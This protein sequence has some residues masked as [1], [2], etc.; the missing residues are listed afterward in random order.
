[1]NIKLYVRRVF[2]TEECDELCPDYLTFLKV[3][4]CFTHRGGR[5]NGHM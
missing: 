2:I 4:A 3:C 5:S 1:M